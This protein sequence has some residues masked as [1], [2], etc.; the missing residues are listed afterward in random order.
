MFRIYGIAFSMRFGGQKLRNFE[1]INRPSYIDNI[2]SYHSK[3]HKHETGVHTCLT[4]LQVYKR[5]TKHELTHLRCHYRKMPVW[6]S[7]ST[8]MYLAFLYSEFVHVNA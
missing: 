8:C 5:S 7:R 4:R 1:L 6:L 3:T 2:K